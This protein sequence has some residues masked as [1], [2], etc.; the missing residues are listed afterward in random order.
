MSHWINPSKPSY[1]SAT[2]KEVIWPPL[3][4]PI[5]YKPLTEE[6]VDIRNMGFTGT[7]VDVPGDRRWL[8]HACSLWLTLE[9]RE[10]GSWPGEAL[11]GC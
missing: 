7:A 2:K 3:S 9:K 5:E 6:M 10:D 8:I 1:M 4:K 11:F